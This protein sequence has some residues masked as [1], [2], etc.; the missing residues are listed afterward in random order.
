MT[1]N[2][3][4]IPEQSTEKYLPTHIEIE[5]MKKTIREENEKAMIENGDMR[6]HRTY[7]T[8]KSPKD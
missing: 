8:S 3:H 5:Q 4:K 2:Y 1:K 6:G 7:G